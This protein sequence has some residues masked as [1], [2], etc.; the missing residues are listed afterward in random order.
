M[1]VIVYDLS[2]V[3]LHGTLLLLLQVTKS[4]NESIGGKKYNYAFDNLS[5]GTVCNYTAYYIYM[6]RS[7]PG[8]NAYCTIIMNKNDGMF[9]HTILCMQI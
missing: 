8:S 9:E 1:Y 3:A 4:S 6:E 5:N 7:S 2:L